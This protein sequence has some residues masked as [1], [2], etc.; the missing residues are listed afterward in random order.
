MLADVRRGIWRPTEPQE[1]T[2]RVPEP[3]FHEF[4]S[5]W[6]DGP[7]REGAEKT[8]AVRWQLSNHLLPFF[9]GY[10]LTEIT[11]AEVDE[12]RQQKVQRGQAV[13]DVDQQDDHAPGADPRGR[14]RARADRPQPAAGRGA[15]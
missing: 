3:T 2:E 15:A 5:E 11:I 1:A 7:E 13:R 12:Y 6:F 8:L 4:A 14:G 9:A 10:R